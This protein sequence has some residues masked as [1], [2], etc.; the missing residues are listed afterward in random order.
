MKRK[1]KKESINPNLWRERGSEVE[2][3]HSPAKRV[4]A[5][6]PKRFDRGYVCFDLCSLFS[7]TSLWLIVSQCKCRNPQLTENFRKTSSRRDY[8]FLHINQSLLEVNVYWIVS[9]QKAKS[10]YWLIWEEQKY[11]MY[12]FACFRQNRL[13]RNRLSLKKERKKEKKK[14][15]KKK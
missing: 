1:R 6:R 5:A 14:K 13:R 15:E 7:H 4:L 11:E 8:Y 3:N 2:S 12:I 9:V 10:T